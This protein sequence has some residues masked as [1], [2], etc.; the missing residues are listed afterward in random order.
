MKYISFNIRLSRSNLVLQVLIMTLPLFGVT[1]AKLMTLCFKVM[2]PCSF[3]TNL[4]KKY[5]ANISTSDQLLSTLGINL[6][7]TLV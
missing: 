1:F 2:R 6:E 5:P 3:S 4:Q 7:I